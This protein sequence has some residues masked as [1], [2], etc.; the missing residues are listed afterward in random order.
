MC[1]SAQ[2]FEACET[3]TSL[4]LGEQ[5]PSDAMGAS[6]AID[7]QRADLGHAR[8]ERRQLRAPNHATAPTGDDK[9]LRVAGKLIERTRQQV[10]LFQVGLNQVMESLRIRWRARA[11]GNGS[12]RACRL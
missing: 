12:R 1:E 10:T 2:R 5:G 11:I 4:Q 7:H 8:A 9:P 3:G 6:A